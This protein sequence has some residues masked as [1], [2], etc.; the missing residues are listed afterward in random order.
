MKSDETEIA[1][2]KYLYRELILKK[3]LSLKRRSA[4]KLVGPDC[5]YHLYSKKEF[6]DDI[7]DTN[8]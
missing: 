4:V 6:N 7:K 5:A 2:K 3:K 1:R 8:H